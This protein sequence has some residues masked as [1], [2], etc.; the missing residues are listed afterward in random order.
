MTVKRILI[1]DDHPLIRR[2]LSISLAKSAAWA[3]CIEA[4]GVQEA[5]KEVARELPD[6]VLADLELEDGSGL[7]LIAAIKKQHPGLPV[8]ILSMHDEDLYAERVLR[9]GGQGYLM[10]SEDPDRLLAHIESALKGEIVL[11]KPMKD[12]ILHSLSGKGRTTRGNL[13]ELSDRELE[14]F[15]LVGDGLPTRKMAEKLS[16]SAKTVE[17]HLSHIK[18]K[19]GVATGMELRRLAFAHFLPKAGGIGTEPGLPGEP[20]QAP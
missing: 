3:V 10:K 5:L 20:S 2:G 9:A 12:K 18:Q 11:S 19:L 15:R 4:E 7:D 13:S 17:T 16:I 14:I 1:V 8:L 6:L